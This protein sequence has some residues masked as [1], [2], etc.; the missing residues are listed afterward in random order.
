MNLR[1]IK[2]FLCIRLTLWAAVA[3][4]TAAA[5]QSALA[6]CP[7]NT[8]LILNHDAEAQQGLFGNA[9]H[10][11]ADWL[12]TPSGVHGLFTIVRYSAGGGFPTASSPG[13]PNRGNYFFSGGPAGADSYGTQDYTVPS[14]CFA[15]IDTGLLPFS[16]SG[17]FGG[18]AGQ[19]DIA[20]LRV[21]FFNA[22]SNNI[23]QTTIGAVS[24]AERGNTTGLLFKSSNGFVPAN[25]R[26]MEIRL[27]MT[28][29]SGDND[30]Y[31]DN[32]DFRFSAPTAAPVSISGRVVNTYG[33]GIK[34]AMIEMIDGRGQTVATIANSFGYFR[35]SGIE[36]GQSIVLTVRSKRYIFDPSSIFVNVEDQVQG[37]VFRSIN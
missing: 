13:P 23:G 35:F 34:G 30:G 8:N 18:F 32:L 14:D 31:A 1:I 26:S 2:R 37:L 9:D 21:T 4:I 12:D 6:I 16:I 27:F 22:N 29:R 24:S 3:I 17:W 15:A 28:Q 5:F 7:T 25:T 10:D 11:V 19:N 20:E 36:A 33:Q